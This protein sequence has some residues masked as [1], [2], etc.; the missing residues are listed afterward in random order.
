MI[1]H[2]LSTVTLG[3][4]LALAPACE[5]DDGDDSMGEGP[6]LGKSLCDGQSVWYTTQCVPDNLQPCETPGGV[7]G[8]C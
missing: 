6:M 2:G 7:S 5:G 1:K 4:A 3:L 8:P